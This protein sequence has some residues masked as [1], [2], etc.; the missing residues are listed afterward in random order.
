MG[1]ITEAAI[2]RYWVVMTITA[3]ACVGATLWAAKVSASLDRLDARIVSVEQSGEATSRE[4]RW[5][6]ESMIAAGTAKA[7]PPPAEGK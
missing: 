5:L 4:I 1:G 2:R 3:G 6:R 7:V